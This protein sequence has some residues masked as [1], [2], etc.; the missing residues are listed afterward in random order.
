M[1]QGV[2]KQQ[3]VSSLAETLRLTRTEVVELELAS[4]N[5]HEDTVIIHYESGGIK[6][7]NIHM[8]SGIAIIRDVCRAID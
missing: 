2:T 8:D 3:L 6:L 4:R 5:D 1:K 7:V